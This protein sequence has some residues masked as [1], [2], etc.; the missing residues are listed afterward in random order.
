[1]PSPHGRVG[2]LL[3]LR[4][5]YLGGEWLGSARHARIPSTLGVDGL[6]LRGFQIADGGR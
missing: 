6:D 2:V 4:D 5:T 3:N 1:V